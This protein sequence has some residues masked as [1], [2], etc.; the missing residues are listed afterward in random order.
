MSVTP[1]VP[2]LE[3]SVPKTPI[4]TC[5]PNLMPFHIGYSGPAPI[6]TYFRVKPDVLLDYGK[7]ASENASAAKLEARPSVDRVETTDSQVTLVSETPSSSDASVATLAG[8]AEMAGAQEKEGGLG[9]GRHF[10]AAFRGRTVRGTKVDLPSGFA[11]IVLSTPDVTP[12]GSTAKAS[13][14][15]QKSTRAK[16]AASSRRGA[17]KAAPVEDAEDDDM[18]DAPELPSGPTK[19]LQAT[20]TFSSFVLWNPDIPADEGRDEYLRSLT[21]WTKL[22]TE[23]SCA[24]V[25]CD[26]IRL[27]F[28]VS[29]DKP[30]R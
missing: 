26:A 1:A 10:V 12:N 29:A 19:V 2:A 25:S 27:N 21:E 22:A 30:L 5:S 7:T 11:G 4:P 23:V 15:A 9:D 16:R 8:D 14:D 17:R 13:S 20:G 24:L 28:A 18:G 6:S 3:L